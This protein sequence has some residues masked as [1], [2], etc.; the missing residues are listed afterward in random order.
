MRFLV[1]FG[2]EGIDCINAQSIMESVVEDLSAKHD[3]INVRKFDY[4]IWNYMSK[5]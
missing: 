1:E 2:Y 4:I 3:G 5:R